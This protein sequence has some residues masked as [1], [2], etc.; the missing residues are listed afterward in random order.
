MVVATTIGYGS[1][2]AAGAVGRAGRGRTGKSASGGL[3]V[4]RK[5][6]LCECCSCSRY[7][8]VSG[9]RSRK[10]FSVR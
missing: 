3:P 5:T 4:R 2:V 9:V 8:F 1:A 7:V 6:A 10:E